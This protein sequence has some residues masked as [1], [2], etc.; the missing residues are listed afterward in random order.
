MSPR[1]FSLRLLHVPVQL[2]TGTSFGWDEKATWNISWDIQTDKEAFSCLE[3][4][5]IN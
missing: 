1:I 2:S 4:L 3:Q 5:E